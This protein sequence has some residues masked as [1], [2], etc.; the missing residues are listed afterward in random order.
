MQ[1]LVERVVNL[2]IYM[3]GRIDQ[4]AE[5]CSDPCQA[6]AFAGCVLEDAFMA[7]T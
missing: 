1:H 7:G 4:I 5:S 3:L 2:Q 6:T